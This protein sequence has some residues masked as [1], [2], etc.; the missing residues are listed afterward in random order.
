MVRILVIYDYLSV[1][2]NALKCKALRMNA[3]EG[4]SAQEGFESL[5]AH[6]L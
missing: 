6:H 4:I 3:K 1:C 2:I 5:F